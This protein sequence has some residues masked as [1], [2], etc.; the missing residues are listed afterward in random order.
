MI[1]HDFCDRPIPLVDLSGTFDWGKVP[2]EEC[3]EQLV[4]LPGEPSGKLYARSKYYADGIAGAIRRVFVRETVRSMLTSATMALPSGMKLVIWDGWRPIEVQRALY[5]D[6]RGT[7]HQGN[8]IRLDDYVANPASRSLRVPPHITGGAVDVCLVDNFAN[9]IDM[10]TDRDYIGP[11]ANT[12]YFEQK[13]AEVN[14]T[15][16]ELGYLRSRRLLYWVMRESGFTNYP[17]EWW[18]FDY[19]N[20]LWGLFAA[21]SAF[22]AAVNHSNRDFNKGAR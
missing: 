22:Y 8:P 18:H 7:W 2:V 6:L 10:G 5:G 21:Q 15:E 1:T 17:F 20:Q 14:L 16:R 12:A 9:L 3:R 13:Y 4:E 11:E 19:G